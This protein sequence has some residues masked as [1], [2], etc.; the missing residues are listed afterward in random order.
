MADLGGGRSQPQFSLESFQL[1]FR[2][3]GQ[4]LNPAVVQIASPAAQAQI[5]RDLLSE[6]TVP[7]T[8]HPSTYHVFPSATGAH[9]KEILP[10]SLQEK[11]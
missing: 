11:P 7:Y 2:T 5:P 1:E 4:H 3:N 10:I 6:I 8:L 9:K